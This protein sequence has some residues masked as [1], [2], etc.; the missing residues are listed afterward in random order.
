MSTSRVVDIIWSCVA[1]STL[2]T[3][4]SVFGKY[5][6][7]PQ[8]ESYVSSFEAYGFL[9]SLL[10]VRAIFFGLL[11]SANAAMCV[12]TARAFQQGSSTVVTVVNSSLIFIFT[13]IAGVIIFGETINLMWSLGAL[14]VLSGVCL[15]VYA[16][17]KIPVSKKKKST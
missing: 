1:A 9:N 13:T 15:I 5:A 11:I 8:L 2:A 14:M 6:T 10:V 3:L 7:S 12:F 17:S 4:A 16:E